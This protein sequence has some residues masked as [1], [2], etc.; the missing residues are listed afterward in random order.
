MLRV[1]ILELFDEIL[2]GIIAPIESLTRIIFR[3]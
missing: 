1:T 2:R 3:F